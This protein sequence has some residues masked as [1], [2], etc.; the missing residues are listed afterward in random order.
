MEFRMTD[1]DRTARF[2]PA[3]F[4]SVKSRARYPPRAPP[5]GTS[6]IGP[7]KPR[8]RAPLVDPDLKKGRVQQPHRF[9]SF[10]QSTPDFTDRPSR[11]IGNRC[12][13]AA[14]DHDTYPAEGWHGKDPLNGVNRRL[15]HNQKANLSPSFQGVLDY[16]AVDC[17]GRIWRSRNV[18]QK[19]RRAT[20]TS[21][22]RFPLASS[23]L[24]LAKGRALEPAQRRPDGELAVI[25]R[26]KC[27]CV[28]SRVRRVNAR[29]VT[30]V[31]W[32]RLS[33]HELT[34]ASATVSG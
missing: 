6:P 29:N 16:R 34:A 22:S 13:A 4:A 14:G 11:L 19:F 32:P 15:P 5:A 31:V 8:L 1:A 21:I 10:L 7:A 33:G 12:L 20:C 23:S 26:M 9:P 17:H 2:Y 28:L 30:V 18:K 27:G 24:P 25:R 3:T